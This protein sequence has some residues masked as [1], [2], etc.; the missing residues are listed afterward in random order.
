MIISTMQ[1]Q[2]ADSERKQPQLAEVMAELDNL[3]K[4]SE[5]LNL[6]NKLHARMAGVL[7]LTGMIEAYSVW[8]MPFVNHELI[9]YSNGS[10]KKKHLFCS[11]HGPHRR[12]AMAFAEQ[13]ID[14]KSSN[15]PITSCCLD[16]CTCFV[17]RSIPTSP[18]PDTPGQ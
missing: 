4:Q 2:N 12:S 5:R 15:H 7:S 8:L 6:A 10:R 14:D 3:K 18:I 16:Q 1:Y 11:G 9:G 17:V 13:L